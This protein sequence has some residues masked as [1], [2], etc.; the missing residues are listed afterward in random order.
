MKVFINQNTVVSFTFCLLIGVAGCASESQSE[1]ES[2]SAVQA[3]IQ[4][5]KVRGVVQTITPSKNFVNIDHEAIPGFMDAM[6][7]MFAVKDSGV[8]D[9]VSVGDSILFTLEV[10]AAMPQV[11]DVEVLSTNTGR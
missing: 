8:V 5:Y 9:G 11:V 4:S 1:A 2:A 7:M 6:A 10:G 3:E